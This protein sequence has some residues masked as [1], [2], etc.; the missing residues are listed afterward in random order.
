MKCA[1]FEM[2]LATEFP[3]L[4]RHLTGQALQNHKYLEIQRQ[5]LAAKML[6]EQPKQRTQCQP[7]KGNACAQ[8][9]RNSRK[10]SRP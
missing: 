8:W 9:W 4:S 10:Q 2:T 6:R 1:G 5:A 7:R 3:S